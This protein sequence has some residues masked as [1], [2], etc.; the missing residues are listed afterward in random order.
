MLKR[1]LAVLIL[2]ACCQAAFA[3]SVCLPLPRLLTLTPMGGQ[4]GTEVDIVV[5]GE[6]LEELGELVFN[7]PGLKAT[8]FVDP[9]G[10]LVPNKYHVV[11]A[12][13]CPPGLYEARVLS[14]LGIS[15]ARV[16]S[17]GNLREITQGTANTTLATALPLSMNSVCNA[18]TT[19]KS[20]DHYTFSAEQGHRYVIHCSARG[21]DS[22]LDPVVILGDERGQDL[23]ADRQGDT[24]DFV[25]DRTGTFVIKVHELTYKGGNEYFYRLHLQEVGSNDPKPVFPSTRAVNACSWPPTGLT[26]QP[27]AEEVEPNALPQGVQKVTLP[28]DLAGTFYPA[29]DVD[30]FEFE[31]KQ[32][33]VWWIEVASERLGRPTDPNVLVQQV[34]KEGD[35]E[36]LVD[37]VEL[38]DI[39]SPVKTSSNGY[40]YDGPPY[41]A[42]SLDVLG[43]VEIK[44]NGTYRINLSDAFGGT[45]TDARNRY[46]LV[47]R[48]A[49]PDFA[50]AAWGLH[51]ELRNGDRNAVSKPLSL[52]AGA[53]VALEV[54]TIRRDGFAG[55][56]QLAMDGLP[57]GVTATGLKIP[58]GANRGLMLITASSDAQVGFANARF[59][60]KADVNGQVVERNVQL[61]QMSWPVPDSWGEIPVPRLVDGVAVS[62]TRS[63]L[64]PM[65]I[66]AKEQ[67]VW[68]VAAG[69]KLTIPLA[70]TRRSEFSGSVIQFITAGPGFE[71][72]PR[73]DVSIQADSHE[74][75]IDLG[76]LKTQPGDYQIA[77]YG[78]AV[79]KYRYDPNAVMT[80]ESEVKQTQAEV[81]RLAGEV[82]RVTDALA[83]A[84]GDTKAQLEQELNSLNTQKKDADGKLA[85]CNQKLKT[86]SDRAAPRDTVDIVVSEPITIRVK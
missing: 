78:G 54:V 68:E 24:L 61:A 25:A 49:A 32:G 56:I 16:F 64:A 20:I 2:F 52:R 42:G 81:D 44:E 10:A 47:V 65:T 74:V 36:V 27:A 45:R 26:S 15:A 23:K 4:Q 21:I 35:Q 1:T 79:A 67:K 55:E 73:F 31:G 38:N 34:K 76:A 63:E 50:V 58:A 85:T 71:G 30:T 3:Q 51:M 33:E 9:N 43:K 29:A 11:I 6:N 39:P 7:H 22:K 77:F 83:T 59:I 75:T 17:V 14:R 19:A 8:P 82:K 72:N 46:R 60:G 69:S 48:Q 70:F 62:V 84:V 5:G 12:P 57:P 18:R 13:D 66:A 80:A 28:C 40:A 53:T 37:V 41:N 86:C